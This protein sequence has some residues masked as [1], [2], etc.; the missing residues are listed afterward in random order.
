MRKTIYAFPGDEW[1]VV[2]KRNDELIT[3]KIALR[4]MDR[5]KLLKS[6]NVQR[7]GR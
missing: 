2:V 6:L 5:S 1:E 4:E 3:V 7:G